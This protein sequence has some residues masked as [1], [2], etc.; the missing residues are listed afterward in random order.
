MAVGNDRNL[1]HEKLDVLAPCALGGVLG[2]ETIPNL[3]CRIVCGT[4]NN[5]L[6]DPVRDGR[7][8][9]ARGVCYA[10]DFVANAGGL[11]RLAGLH[12]GMTE[13]RIDEKVAGIEQTTAEVLREAD[14]APS[15]AEAA[16]EFARRR[17]ESAPTPASA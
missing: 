16:I 17:I 1:F 13:A 4:A 9:K 12:L 11:I 7:A 8:L 2:P 14:S 5:Q 6:V 10:P 3:R 15:T